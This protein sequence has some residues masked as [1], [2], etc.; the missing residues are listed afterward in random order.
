MDVSVGPE[1]HGMKLESKLVFL[2]LPAHNY[3][4]K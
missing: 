1:E 4:H 2:R 3:S